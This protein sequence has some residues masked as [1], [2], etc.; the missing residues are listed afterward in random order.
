MGAAALGLALM[1]GSNV[2]NESGENQAI[3]AQ[4]SVLGAEQARQ[5]D[6]TA[7]NRRMLLP[8]IQG[9][10]PGQ[11]LTGIARIGQQEQAPMVQDANN[12]AAAS[13]SLQGATPGANQG[14]ISQGTQGAASSALQRAAIIARLRAPGIDANQR[15]QAIQDYGMKRQRLAV[16]A[17][18]S[19]SVLPIEME[20]AGYQGSR[21]RALAQLL[22]LGGQYAYTKGIYGKKA[23]GGYSNSTDPSYRLQGPAQG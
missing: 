2:L 17:A 6:L 10:A 7:Q 8:L 21:Q 22:A 4:R 14:Q 15:D 23:P 11:R 5:A 9:Q 12:V 16:K 13:A 1:G 20:A 19:E 3:S 18:D